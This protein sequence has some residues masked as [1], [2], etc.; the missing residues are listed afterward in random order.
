MSKTELL[1]AALSEMFATRGLPALTEDE[2]VV[3]CDA[4]MDAVNAEV[5]EREKAA[6][7]DW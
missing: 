5:D 7:A 4:F 1:A 6:R 2:R 3:L